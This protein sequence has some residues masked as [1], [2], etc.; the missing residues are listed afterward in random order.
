MDRGTWL[1]TVH[2]VTGLDTSEQLSPCTHDAE[3]VAVAP[4]TGLA[5]FVNP[6]MR[7]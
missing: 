5:T 2:G 3:R 7:Q 1:A 4:A 6:L